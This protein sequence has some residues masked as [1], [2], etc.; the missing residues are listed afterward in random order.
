MP[1]LS[2]LLNKD[3]DFR[4]SSSQSDISAFIIKQELNTLSNWFSEN[5]LIVNCSKTT[6][7]VFGTS[8]RLAKAS[9]PALKMSESFLPVK[10]FSKYLGVILIRV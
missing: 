5:G 3:K 6:A 4:A 1:H 8:Q 10:D 7:L 9:R 2:I